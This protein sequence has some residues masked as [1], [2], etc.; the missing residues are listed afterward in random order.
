MRFLESL[1]FQSKLL[2]ILLIPLGGI[3]GLGI[4]GIQEKHVLINQMERMNRL[5]SLAVNMS[6]LVHQ[7][8]RERGLTAGF[9][10][11]RGQRFQEELTRQRPGTDQSLARL[12]TQIAT[13]DPSGQ[14]EGELG[15]FFQSA[16]GHLQQADQIRF[17]VD[18][19]EISSGD[20]IAYFSGMNADFLI[21]IDRI[22]GLAATAEISALAR[23]Y[24]TF[25]Q[26]KERAGLERA[27]IAETLS[28]GRFG[29]GMYRRFS[30]LVSEQE[31]LFGIFY[32]MAGTGERALFDAIANDPAT[33][34]VGQMR[35]QLFRTGH[36]SSLY[37][38]LGQLYQNMALRGA[39]HSIKN[40]L[41]R[42]SL[43]GFADDAFDPAQQQRHYQEQ[44]E[45]NHQA[46]RAIVERI[47]SLSPEELSARQRADVELV[48]ANIEEYRHSA[49]VI[50][51]LQNQ[52]KHLHEID[53]DATAGVKIDDGPADA[54]I[55]RLVESTRVG[56]F[57]I[58]AQLWFQASTTKIDRFKALEDRL[59][60]GLIA[61]GRFLERE[62]RSALLGYRLFTLA[63]MIISLGFGVTLVR[64]LRDKTSR[65]VELNR[66]ISAGDLSV[67]FPVPEGRALDEL[68]LIA[69]SMNRMVIGLDHTTR[70]KQ[71]TMRALEDSEKR[72]RSMLDTAPDAILSLDDHGWVL[73][74]N[75]AGEDLFG[76]YPGTL[77]GCSVDD[78]IPDLRQALAQGRD[79][80]HGRRVSDIHAAH[81]TLEMEGLC[82]DAG[83][84]PLEI[85]LSS[86]EIGDATRHFTLILKDITER[87]Q[88]KAALSRAYA[89]LEERVRDRTRELEQTNQQ[90]FAEIDERIR[91]EQGLSLAAKVFETANEGILIT[92]AQ[93]RIIKSNHAFTEISGYSHEEVFG[94]NPSMLSSGRQGS[95]FYA[96]MWEEILQNG[97]WS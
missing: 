7:L 11:S 50:I 30:A 35:E 54:A 33:L 49:Q 27:V 60:E 64:Q 17:Q 41:I 53:M 59:A 44:F 16:I 45:Q 24:N 67:R 38:L 5:S 76:Y 77:T 80:A 82:R 57:D 4:V 37:V 93:V 88:V 87:R 31:T 65:I 40:L 34:A 20:A 94:R 3:L 90:L 26:G 14:L 9:L 23:N 69:D 56:Q 13:L 52:G 22:S 72:V 48:W 92:D 78:L 47:L 96:R 85:S 32:A 71:Q 89:E 51:E 43:Y 73:E 74:I 91:A 29:P 81:A 63:I 12:T 86:Y 66:R 10:G 84:F 95:E 2:L 58:D 19:L 25:L 83:T 36:A 97:A 55:R 42:G 8:Q 75:P 1:S 61:R 46:I 28:A 6:H 15:G 18:R 70:L 68:D 79:D 39:Y 21:A 62:A